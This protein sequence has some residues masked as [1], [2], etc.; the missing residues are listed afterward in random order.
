MKLREWLTRTDL[1][2]LEYLVRP[3]LP[4]GGIV[5]LHGPRGISKTNVALALGLA[6]A[7][8]EP[9]L[10]FTVPRP[11]P[12]LYVDGEM[13]RILVQDRL[14]KFV[15]HTARERALDRFNY[16]SYADE[17]DALGFG[18]LGQPTSG[19]R[20]RLEELLAESREGQ[21]PALLIL[22]N[23]SCLVSVDDENAASA[24]LMNFLKWL[25]K[26]RAQNVS[27][28]LIHH[29]GKLDRFGNSTQHGSSALERYPD[30]IVGLS[31]NGTA[32]DGT[33]PVR[34]SYEKERSFT[35]KDRELF[36]NIR[37]DDEAK[38]AWVEV[39][40]SGVD[41]RTVA[42]VGTWRAN[43]ELSVR[44]IADLTGVG[45]S[46]VHEILKREPDWTGQPSRKNSSPAG[47]S[48]AG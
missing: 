36:F 2:P 25:L 7:Q 9:L 6:V 33:I 30:C 23:K 45:K 47:E 27:T 46:R 1:P 10:G 32:S 19:G 37:Y 3:W 34:W 15:N 22:D 18:D 12:V 48:P 26:L 44:Q 16:A 39:S 4:V 43:P 40:D 14:R 38:L 41:A 5:L 42:V 17:P 21:E 28:V 11:R 31:A 35:P 24:E 13:Q 8:G 20:E 29:D